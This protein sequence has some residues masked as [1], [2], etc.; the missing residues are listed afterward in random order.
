MGTFLFVSRGR[1]RLLPLGDFRMM[2]ARR[3]SV[4]IFCLETFASEPW[5]W[6]CS[7]LS[8]EIFVCLGT[9]AWDLSLGNFSLETL[10]WELSF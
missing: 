8:L 10:A 9:S 2:L 5:L 7:A 1:L 3:L 4:V 6:N